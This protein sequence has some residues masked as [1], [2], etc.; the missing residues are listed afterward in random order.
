M[1]WRSD[2]RAWVFDIL[3]LDA[4]KAERLGA[5]ETFVDQPLDVPGRPRAV[6][7]P[8]H[9]RGHSALHFPERGVLHVGDAM[10][11]AH[12]LLRDSGPQPSPGF[13]DADHQQALDSLHRIAPLPADVVVAGHGP[14]STARPRRP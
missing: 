9:T 14:A 12:A 8:G 5:V 13:F 4:T 6:H 3:R 10:M 11:T 2:V 1:L 7:T